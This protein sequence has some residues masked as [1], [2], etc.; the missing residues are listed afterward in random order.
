SSA[1]GL[2]S[3]IDTIPKGPTWHCMK[4]DTTGY[5]MKDPVY[6]FWHDTL[7]VTWEIFGNLVFTWHMEYDPYQVYEGTEHEYGEWMSGDEAH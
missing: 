7:E 2:L 6:V 4:I 3:H 1:Q 5:V